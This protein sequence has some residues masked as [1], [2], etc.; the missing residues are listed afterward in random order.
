MPH[1]VFESNSDEITTYPKDLKRGAESPA[2]QAIVT[3][4]GECQTED[5][6]AA[7]SSPAYRTIPSC[8]HPRPTGSTV[9]RVSLM[10]F[11]L[12]SLAHRDCI[13]TAAPSARSDEKADFNSVRSMR[14]RWSLTEWCEI[15][16]LI[17]LFFCIYLTK[18]V[19]RASQFSVENWVSA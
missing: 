12:L 8:D 1:S 17:S 16:H 3:Q 4:L 5:L 15:I 6:E 9:G 13:S 10:S 19:C 18:Y 14:F 11:A 7:G 2:H